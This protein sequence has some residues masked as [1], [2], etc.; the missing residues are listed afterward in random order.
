M[1]KILDFMPGT[2]KP[3]PERSG[4][5]NEESVLINPGKFN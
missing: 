4:L 2:V 3:V 5:I 1:L